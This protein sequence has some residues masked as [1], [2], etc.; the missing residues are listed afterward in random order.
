MARI[1]RGGAADRS[2]KDLK[3][4]TKHEVVRVST[5]GAGMG[6]VVFHGQHFQHVSKRITII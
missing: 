3:N 2:G 4:K 1:M 6:H 5:L